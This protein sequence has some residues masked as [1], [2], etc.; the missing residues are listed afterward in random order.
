MNQSPTDAASSPFACNMTALSPT[1]RSAHVA[2]AT[3]LFG[4]LVQQTRELPDGYAYR[5][6][7]AHYWLLA[8]FITNERRC[9]PFL[10]FTLEVAPHDGPI[11]LHL[12]AQGDAKPFLREE[13]GSITS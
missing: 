2:L 11:W 12:T 10:S 6:D 1:Q 4:S 7:G 8:R 5:F 3:Q 9:C 13:L